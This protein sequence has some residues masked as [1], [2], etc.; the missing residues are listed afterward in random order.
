MNDTHNDQSM[1][2]C[3]YIQATGTASLQMWNA[4]HKPGYE[5]VHL[6]FVSPKI[7]E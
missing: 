2:I 1:K 4:S 7:N 5:G 3:L 6:L